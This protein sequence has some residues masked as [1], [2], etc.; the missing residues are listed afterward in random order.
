MT[1]LGIESLTGPA[2]AVVGGA[3]VI[4]G[5][6]SIGIGAPLRPDHIRRARLPERSML[7]THP[8]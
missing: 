1:H 6:T 4:A 8:A 2:L 5:A 7:A 3:V